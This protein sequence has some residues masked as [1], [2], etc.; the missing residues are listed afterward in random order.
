MPSSSLTLFPHSC[1]LRRLICQWLSRHVN[2]SN[3]P[4]PLSDHR[5]TCRHLRCAPTSTP[6][7]V[8]TLGQPAGVAFTSALNA[9]F[10]FVKNTRVARVVFM[11]DFPPPSCSEAFVVHFGGAVSPAITGDDGMAIASHC[12]GR[13]LD[14]HRHTARTRMSQISSCPYFD[15]D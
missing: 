8:V 10:G 7:H 9:R 5:K 2:P 6:R 12:L 15:T 13:S 1:C 4:S 3:A 14:H 11:E